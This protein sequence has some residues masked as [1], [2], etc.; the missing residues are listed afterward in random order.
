[1][2]RLG[3][4]R[5]MWCD[6]WSVVRW[7][8]RSSNFGQVLMKGCPLARLLHPIFLCLGDDARRTHQA[9]ELTLSAE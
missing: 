4:A 9:L 2:S 8:M 3:A 6:D 7:L 1:M 5:L